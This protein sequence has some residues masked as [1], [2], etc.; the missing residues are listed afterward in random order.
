MT[1]PE[2]LI[3]L[4]ETS[5]P[6]DAHLMFF[7]SM[8]ELKKFRVTYISTFRH[9]SSDSYNRLKHDLIGV[10]EL[11]LMDRFYTCGMTPASIIFYNCS[12]DDCKNDDEFKADIEMYKSTPH[13]AIYSLTAEDISEQ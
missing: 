9:F 5:T 2:L 13:V 1:F 10:L 3:K 8:S 12:L 6:N 4:A 11:C 7:K